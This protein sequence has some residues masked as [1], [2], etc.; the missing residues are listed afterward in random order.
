MEGCNGRAY[1]LGEDLVVKIYK[2]NEQDSSRVANRETSMLDILFNM[3]LKFPNSQVGCYAFQT[4][5]GENYLVST[6]VAGE[7]PNPNAVN[8]N[9]EN[10]S[11]LVDTIY[12][13]DTCASSFS[14]GAG[15]RFMNYDFNGK[16][17]KITPDKAGVFDFEYSNIEKIDDMIN[18]KIIQDCV[19]I[20]CHQSDTSPLPSNLRSFE[21]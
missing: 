15:L 7:S 6:R 11:S 20:N 3:G 17:I 16:N 19:G 1:N 8:F 12:N 4:P 5:E 21:L 13:M 18:Q 14:E 10:L 2:R 9:K